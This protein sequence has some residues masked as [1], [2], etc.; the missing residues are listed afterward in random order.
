MYV[1]DGINDAPALATADVSLAIG[2]GMTGMGVFTTLLI[3]ILQVFL[4]KYASGLEGAFNTFIKVKLRGDHEKA[5]E[6]LI[7]CLDEHEIEI[8]NQRVNRGNDGTIKVQL[9]VKVPRD[10]RTETLSVLFDDDEDNIS[11]EI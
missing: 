5:L 2:A 6:R 10:V 4:H 7:H 8:I 3:I 9:S 11:I 1:G